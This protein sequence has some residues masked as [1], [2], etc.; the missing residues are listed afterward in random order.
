MVDDGDSSFSV[1]CSFFAT[2]LSQSFIR[3]IYIV[4]L[5]ELENG[6]LFLVRSRRSG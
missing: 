5:E 2:I 1:S 4:W 6:W 3:S